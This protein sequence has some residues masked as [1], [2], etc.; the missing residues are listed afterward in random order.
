MRSSIEI[1]YSFER[2]NIPGKAFSTDKHQTGTATNV[3]FEKINYFEDKKIS[4][5][6]TTA[7]GNISNNTGRSHIA[8]EMHTSV[9]KSALQRPI[10]ALKKEYM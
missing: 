10:G 4:H 6:A 8:K 2:H 1:F 5:Q 7:P 9:G 3:S